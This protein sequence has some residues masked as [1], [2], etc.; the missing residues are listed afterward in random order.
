MK[1]RIRGD[2][3]RMRLTQ[4]EVASIAEGHMVEESLDFGGGVRLRY[5]VEPAKGAAQLGANFIGGRITLSVPYERA[6]EWARGGEVAMQSEAGAL[7]GI[8]IEK[9]FACLK[10]RTNENEDESDMFPNP[11]LAGGH[12]T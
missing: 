4:K 11:N 8:L 1:L 3:I 12:C 10:L 2:S 7:P 5:S 9:D 6:L